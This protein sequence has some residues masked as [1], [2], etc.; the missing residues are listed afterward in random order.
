MLYQYCLSRHI[1]VNKIG[2]LLV[3]HGDE[4]EAF[5]KQTLITA[6]NNGVVHVGRTGLGK[7]DFFSAVL[8][9]Q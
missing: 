8:N 4:E 5:L 6:K 1:P 7:Q 2:K 3:A 9:V